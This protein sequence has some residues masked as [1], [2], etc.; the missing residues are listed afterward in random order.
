MT[1]ATDKDLRPLAATG[2]AELERADLWRRLRQEGDSRAREQLVLTYAPLVKYIAGRMAS[3]L[4]RHVE[5]ADLVSYG[6]SG[7][8]TAIERFDPRR[9]VKFETFAATRIRGAIVDELRSL[10]WVPRTVRRKARGI[11][12]VN[13]DLERRLGRAPTDAETADA[14]GVSVKE[15]RSSLVE[16]SNSSIVALDEVWTASDARE[17]DSLLDRIGDPKAADP[18]RELAANDLRERLSDAIARLPERE[19]LVVAL[20]YYD[21]LTLAEI[22]EVLG[23]TESRTS[24][25]RTKAILR[26][27]SALEEHHGFE[28]EAA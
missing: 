16:I 2:R 19:Q 18:V 20:Y 17:G 12:R 22:A 28:A 4:P 10:D 21:N 11:Q 13:A 15:L 26:L 24:Q 1:V 5:E 8:L 7:L 6:L 9:E 14:M 27:Q 25:L 23:V 3:R